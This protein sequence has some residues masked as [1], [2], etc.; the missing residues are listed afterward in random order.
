LAEN[1]V[2]SWVVPK[3]PQLVDH[4]VVQKAVLK[5]ERKAVVKAE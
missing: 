1:S 2:A 5:V 4:L 3:V